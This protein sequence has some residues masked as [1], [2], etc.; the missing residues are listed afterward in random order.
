MVSLMQW[1]KFKRLNGLDLS[2]SFHQIIPLKFT[3]I[4][5]KNGVANAS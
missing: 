1:L 5:L 3:L 2:L 4:V